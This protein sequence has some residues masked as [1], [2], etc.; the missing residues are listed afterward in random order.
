MVQSIILTGPTAV[1]KSGLAIELAEK[2]SLEIINADSVC[3][4]REFNIGSAKPSRS[5]LSRV[6]HHLIDVASPM[7]NYHAGQFLRDCRSALTDI[8][9]RGRRA[10]IVG[11]SGFYLK[12]LL[13]GLWDAPSSDPVFRQGLEDVSTSE[14]F[15]RLQLQDHDHALKIGPSDRYRIIR[16]LEIITL[17]G[18]RPSDLQNEMLQTR[19]P[20]FALWVL[21]RDKED[22]DSRMKLRVEQMLDAGWIEET[23]TL[24][25]KYPDSKTLQAVGYRQVLD[26]LSNKQPS[27]RKLRP[28]LQGLIDEIVLSHRQLAK[29]QRTWFKNLKPEENFTLERD[30]DRLIE[31]MMSFY[32]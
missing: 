16:A 22:L 31:K 20:E 6:P 10:L 32:Q 8:H 18:R 24:Q 29:Q 27:G 5:E 13:L 7:E 2:L 15:E 11:G 23:R 14:L 25:E 1:G 19:N 30:R 28:G 21:D 9:S 12:S 17:S 26:H 3:F 4:Y